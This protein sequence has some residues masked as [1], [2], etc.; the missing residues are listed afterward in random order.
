MKNLLKGDFMT[1]L[2]AIILCFLAIST[3][4]YSE[5]R[6]DELTQFEIRSY[7]PIEA[8]LKDL[9]FE[10]RM[11][12]L[13]ELLSKNLVIGK[14]VDIYFKVHWISS[15]EFLV[16]VEGFPGDKNSFKEVKEDLKSLILSKLEFVIP[17]KNSEKLKNYSLKTETL[18]TGKVIHAV[19]LSYTFPASEINLYFD[20]QGKIKSM[21][22]KIPNSVI[23]TDYV[24]NPKSWSNNKYLLDKVTSYTGVPGNSLTIIHDLEYQAFGGIGLLTKLTI[25]NIQE[26]MIPGKGKEKAKVS[27]KEV[28]SKLKF[29]KY[30]INTGLALKVINEGKM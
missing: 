20:K 22:T 4:I 24:Y 27:K 3:S 19:D 1:R 7:F 15:G 18:S 28:I 21:E 26:M 23:K 9:V 11:D 6:V 17:Q 5:Q 30:E 16:I 12:G 8:G 2:Y 10:V 29:S 14:R 25:K 13:T